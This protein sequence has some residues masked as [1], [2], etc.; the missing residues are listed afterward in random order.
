M[1]GDK[2]ELVKE[3]QLFIKEHIVDQRNTKLAME[4]MFNDLNKYFSPVAIVRILNLNEPLQMLDDLKL[5]SLIVTLN[6]YYATNIDVENWFFKEEF[7]EA[8]SSKIDTGVVSSGKVIFKD[9]IFNGDNN[10]PVYRCFLDYNQLKEISDA[11]M[12][13]YNVS[14]QRIGTVV[15][16]GIS[17]VIIPSINEVAVSQIGDLVAKEKFKSNDIILNILRNDDVKKYNY[18]SEEKTLTVDTELEITDGAHRL[19]GIVR[20]LNINP[21]AKGSIGLTIMNMTIEEAGNLVYQIAQT[22]EHNRELIEKYSDTKPTV[23]FIKKLNTIGSKDENFLYDNIDLYAKN[24][25][26][27]ATIKF[28]TLYDVMKANGMYEYIENNG[29][30]KRKLLQEFVIEFF[31]LFNDLFKENPKYNLMKSNVFLCGM[32]CTAFEM[33]KKADTITIKDIQKIID[34]F[35]FESIDYTI[36]KNEIRNEERIIMKTIFGELVKSNRKVG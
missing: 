35:D 30:A 26:D 15:A 12:L 27:S 33:Y 25:V 4:K 10:N 2:L 22:N 20:G 9:V 6:K 29:I 24:T 34:R 21:D 17:T 36:S 8:M 11:S 28:E 3:I 23:N 32:M 16:R 31:S 19:Y 13:S 7:D 1:K 5:C 14:A 18:D